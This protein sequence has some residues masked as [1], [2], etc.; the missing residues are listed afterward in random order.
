MRLVALHATFA[1]VFVPNVDAVGPCSYRRHSATGPFDAFADAVVVVV[2]V[3]AVVVAAFSEKNILNKQMYYLFA[4]MTT[5]RTNCGKLT[6]NCCCFIICCACAIVVGG[7]CKFGFLL[8]FTFKFC[9][10]SLLD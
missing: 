4:G 10:I 7:A 8:I 2:A 5:H 6:C 9:A 3:D 1:V